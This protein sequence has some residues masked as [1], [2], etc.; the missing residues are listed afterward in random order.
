VLN[1]GRFKLNGISAHF[2]RARHTRTGAGATTGVA[3]FLTE[4]ADD[5]ATL[6]AWYVNTGRA[7]L[8]HVQAQAGANFLGRQSG[9]AVA[10]DPLSATA[11]AARSTTRRI[12]RLVFRSAACVGDFTTDHRGT[13]RT[14]DPVVIEEGR[15]GS[16]LWRYHV[17]AVQR[18]IRNNALGTRIQAEGDWAGERIPP[19]SAGDWNERGN[20][21][22]IRKKTGHL[23][24]RVESRVGLLRDR[25]YVCVFVCIFSRPRRILWQYDGLF[26]A[27]DQGKPRVVASI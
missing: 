23:H 2:L 27:P 20:G 13:T 22:N 8:G 7:R 9:A 26:C 6:S 21:R 11:R 4:G 24:H 14:F 19:A 15:S 5:S 18:G 1:V 10:R 12:V 17:N 25:R 16:A 3:A